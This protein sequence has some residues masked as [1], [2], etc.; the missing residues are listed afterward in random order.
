MGDSPLYFTLCHTNTLFYLG[1]GIY[2]PGRS[3]LEAVHSEVTGQSCHAHSAQP[4][5]PCPPYPPSPA[6]PSALPYHH[7]G[8]RSTA[9]LAPAIQPYSIDLGKMYGH[10]PLVVFSCGSKHPPYR[11]MHAGRPPPRRVQHLALSS[12]PRPYNVQASSSSLSAPSS[13]SSSSSK[14]RRSR[15]KFTSR[16][17]VADICRVRRGGF[18]AI[19][20]GVKGRAS[21]K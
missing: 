10:L 4:Y 7:N 15:Q 13:S 16:C 14:Q 2:G 12:S 8:G 6:L 11:I 1:L 21:Q 3:A 17:H 9:S 20:C 18:G 19:P 5:R